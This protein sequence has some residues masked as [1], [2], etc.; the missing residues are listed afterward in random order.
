MT[1]RG[2]ASELSVVSLTVSLGLGLAALVVAGCHSR[3]A[4]DAPRG[5]KAAPVALGSAPPTAAADEGKLFQH[6]PQPVGALIIS[7][8]QHGY[9]EPCG[10]T[11]GQR[12]GLARRLDLIERLRKQG[13]PLAL[14]DLGSLA[15]DPVAPFPHNMGGLEESRIRYGIALRA[16]E[17]MGYDAVALSADDLKLGVQEVMALYLNPP[18]PKLKVV[19]AN[20]T[21]DKTLGAE[22][23]VP[24]VRT[25]AGPVDI[26][27]TAVIAP[28]NFEAL[29]DPVKDLMLAYQAPEN[30]LSG[31]LAEL[32]RD[33]HMQVLLVQGPEEYAK[34]LAAAHP[35][36]EVIVAKSRSVDPPKESETLN[37]GK[38]QLIMV[39]QKGQN[40]G[41]LGLY[42]GADPTKRFR[43]QMLDLHSRFNGKTEAMRKLV[44][45]DFQEELRN[46]Q[47]LQTYVR[48]PYVF[49][50][51][52]TGASYVGAETCKQCHPNTY[53][54]WAS[55]GH[56]RAYEALTS[57][58][59]RNREFD[60]Q[61]VGCHTTGFEYEG[62]FVSA[63]TTPLLKGNQCENCHG[64]GSNHA[65]NPTDPAITRTMHRVA[66][67][68][69]KNQ[70]CI[71]C[72]S[73]DDSPKFNFGT[74]WP[75][76]LHTGLDKYDD[77]KVRVGITAG[78]A[79]APADG[80]AAASGAQP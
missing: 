79:P 52:P 27:I 56:A 48:R 10:C 71:R 46:N 28:E 13:W 7:G 16:L 17:M 9:L 65:A 38:T 76:I 42:Q 33:T 69:D 47:V 30:V 20:V 3:S 21:P 70:R 8:E 58:P 40:V 41:V 4:H 45:E 44:D 1:H 62:G 24:M 63:E 11:A 31:V 18:G 43:Y 34:R 49:F 12:G 37:D 51:G 80:E 68:F 35:G 64:P 14:V 15:N 50:D 26:G 53:A 67:D 22:L 60:A 2:R 55:T 57:N 66:S 5:K 19:S 23:L 54:K 32:E 25:K 61:C 29:N 39:G 73:E 74:Y 75:K 78:G 72:H 77:P 6:W 59:K 36:F